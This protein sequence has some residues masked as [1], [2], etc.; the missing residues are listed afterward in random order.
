MRAASGSSRMPVADRATGCSPWRSPDWPRWAIAARSAPTANPATAPGS[1][2]RST[3][4]SSSCWPAI[5]PRDG[6]PS[7]RC[8]CPAAAS[9][10]PAA[11]A[12]S[13]RS[14]RM[15]GCRWHAGVRSRSTRRRW[16]RPRPPRDP[17]SPT[18][19]SPGRP[20]PP[21]TPA[22]WPTT[23]SSVGWSWPGAASRPRSATR[24]ARSPTWP[25][26][27]PR[28]APSSTR[29]WSPVRGCRSSSPTS[30]R[31]CRSGTRSSTSATRRIRTRSGSSPSRSAR[32]RTTARS[33]RSAATASRSAAAAATS[34]R[35]RSRPTSSPPARCSHPTARTRSRSTSRSSC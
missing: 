32:S 6:R 13:R 16:A 25:S 29:A 28:A 35:S 4:P 7:C 21:T 30:G 33:T 19:S 17:G 23:P 27:L 22:R 14:S 15:P 1:P 9:S 5:S 10:K 20:A 31:R 18:R 34:A 11:G 24:A 2:S 12:W 3:A 8:S 26:R